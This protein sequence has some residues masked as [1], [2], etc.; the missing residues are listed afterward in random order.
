MN[1]PTPMTEICPEFSKPGAAPTSWEHARAVLV[2]AP[3]YQVTTVRPDGRPHVTPLLGVWVDDSVCFCT[4]PQERKAVNLSKNPHCVMSTGDNSLESGPDLVVEG[5]G[6]P[7]DDPA[8]LDRIA[9]AYE[10]KYGEAITSP[11]GTWFGLGDQV[12]K[13]AVLVVRV[14]PVKAFA[15]GNAPVFS[16]TRYT[17]AR[18]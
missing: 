18:T 8:G 4:G 7:V 2:E 3:L 17:F 13:A 10:R 6:A 1:A 5:T 12:R 9:E 16:Q 11:E 14:T 15:F